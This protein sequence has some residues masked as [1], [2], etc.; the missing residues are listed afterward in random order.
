[1]T[2]FRENLR[3]ILAIVACNFVFLIN[4]TMIKLASAE[5][6]LGQIITIRGTFATIVLVPLVATAGL[7][8]EIRLVRQPMV[9]WRTLAE[10]GAAYFFLIA[11]FHIPIANANTIV[12]V[13]PL[14]VTACA[15][16]FLGHT[17]GWRRWIAIM[18]GF[19]GVLIVIRPG[20][21]GFNAYGLLCLVSAAFITV[22]D[23]AT[24]VMPAS[25]PTLLIALTTA[26]VVGLTG[27]IFAI[28]SGEHWVVPSV[29]ALLLLA[30][31]V[32]FLVG[33]YLLSVDFMRHGD[34]AVVAPFR[35]TVILW[36]TVVGFVVWGETPDLPMLVGSAIIIAAG[37]YTFHRE[38]RLSVRGAVAAMGE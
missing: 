34:I 15:A 37:V 12:Q 6:P 33:G 27:P 8:R 38:R 35:Y 29:H 31:A 7:A 18:I 9:V 14:A 5:L 4:D 24:R 23:M 3:G 28:L 10:I 11:L 13:V 2:P 32:V 26:V 36:A 19:I 17:V 21:E 20:L 30:T 22:R 25:V 1:M 16:I